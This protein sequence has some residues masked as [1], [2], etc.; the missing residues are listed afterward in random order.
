MF[1]GWSAIVAGGIFL[2]AAVEGIS[3]PDLVTGHF[4][5][6]TLDPNA[7]INPV[8]NSTPTG[9]NASG[10][11][12]TTGGNVGTLD[13][14]PVAEWIIPVIQWARDPKRGRDKWTGTVTSGYR[15]DAQQI[16]AANSYG[17]EHYG[18]AG[19]L[20][21]NHTKKTYPGGAIDVTKPDELNNTLQK[22]PGPL[23]LVWGG[24]V[25]GDTVHFSATGH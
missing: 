4:T 17:L 24:P 21:S 13:G 9:T 15:T 12:G 19:P 22:Y 25:I 20:G 14:H 3:I 11:A 5:K 18:P 7:G 1:W 2:Y 8:D 6:K 16:A 23:K 10:T